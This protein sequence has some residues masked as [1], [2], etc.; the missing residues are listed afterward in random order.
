MHGTGA[1]CYDRWDKENTL[2]RRACLMV[3]L[4]GLSSL[5]ACRSA[6]LGASA[7]GPRP[8]HTLARRSVDTSEWVAVRAAF[9]ARD[10]PTRVVAVQAAPTGA[11]DASGGAAG[12]DDLAKASQN[13]ISS[14][15]SLPLQSNTNFGI[16]EFD[17]TQEVL[18]IQPVIP[19]SIGK[20]TLVNRTIFPIINQPNV[21]AESGSW[22]GL[23]DISHTTFIVPPACGPLTVGL[24]PNIII[25]TAS[26]EYLGNRRWALGPSGV[27][28]LTLDKWVIGAL[29]S[30][31]WSIDD[32]GSRGP[33]VNQFLTQYFVNYNLPKGWYLTSAPIIT[34]DWTAPSDQRWTVPV[35]G[36]LGRVFKI[37]DQ[38]VNAGI[39]AYYNVVKPD[40]AAD[41]SLRLQMTFLFPK[42]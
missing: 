7:E 2:N 25:P 8:A 17:R 33:Q 36:G 28:V 9:P 42:N 10:V 13:P 16:G 12:G 21:M 6:P 15:I 27:F 4:L 30:N 5:A 41:W 22:S 39:Q 38:P 31:V 14:L 37:G 3:A 24:G 32:R 23:G 35:G 34:A 29:A 1:P 18:N 40:Q 26:N 19:V 20:W 11:A